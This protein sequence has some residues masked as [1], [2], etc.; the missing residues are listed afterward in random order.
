M[1]FAGTGAFRWLSTALLLATVPTQALASGFSLQLGA[2]SME[3]P[4]PFVAED[5]ASRLQRTNGISDGESRQAALSFTFNDAWTVAV[6]HERSRLHYGDPQVAGCGL[7]VTR[8]TGIGFCQLGAPPPGRTIADHAREWTVLVERSF[9][10]AERF[11]V[12]TALGFG[13]LRWGSDKDLEAATFSTCLLDFPPSRVRADCIPVDNRA[14]ASGWMGELRGAFEATRSITLSAGA[15]WQG[16]RHDA[17]RYNALT[18][19]LD[20]ARR[21]CEPF[22]WC[23]RRPQQF[24]GGRAERRGDWWWYTAAIDW[25]LG[26]H[27]TLGIDGAWGG[28]RDWETLGAS[29]AYRW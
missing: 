29:I 18:R 10:V 16:Y 24:N 25:D 28:S 8:V 20:A 12:A 22:D 27:W 21:P 17:Y 23:D 7:D 9:A 2:S 6:H 11:E 26:E 14:Q 3:G 13:V 19:F 5:F 15:H 4:N 1:D